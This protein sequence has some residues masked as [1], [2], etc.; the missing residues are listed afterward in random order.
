MQSCW[1][2]KHKDGKPGNQQDKD[3]RVLPLTITL[4]V[5]CGL[6]FYLGG[7]FC[8]EKNELVGKLKAVAKAVPPPKEPTV[9]PL[10][11]KPISFSECRVEYQD[12][13]PCTDPRVQ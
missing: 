12:Y 5:L 8:S 7:I 13:T 10:Q 2:M 3:V 1:K 4:I 6:S 9:S 11:I